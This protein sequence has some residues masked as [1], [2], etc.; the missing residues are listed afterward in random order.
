M[1][2]AIREGRGPFHDEKAANLGSI[3]AIKSP[4]VIPKKAPGIVPRDRTANRPC[5]AMALLTVASH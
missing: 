1:K 5:S 4:E 2:E 3:G